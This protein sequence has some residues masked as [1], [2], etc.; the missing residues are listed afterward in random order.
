MAKLW[1][2]LNTVSLTVNST[3]LSMTVNS[4]GVRLA[5]ASPLR[6]ATFIEWA[7]AVS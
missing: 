7:E 6:E 3:K 5:S 4:A 2:N 1:R